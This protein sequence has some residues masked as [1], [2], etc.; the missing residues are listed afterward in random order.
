MQKAKTAVIGLDGATFQILKAY[1]EQGIMPNIKA[2]MDEG[3]SADLL[4]TIP[5]ITGPAWAAFMTG[6]DPSKTGIYDWMSIKRFDWDEEDDDKV[7]ESLE[8]LGYL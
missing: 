8:S 5:P 7:R 6:K 2:F 1:T 3:V 4:S